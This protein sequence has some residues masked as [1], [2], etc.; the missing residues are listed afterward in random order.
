MNSIK[1][2][3]LTVLLLSIW[4]IPV[5]A[6]ECTFDIRLENPTEVKVIY[7]VKWWSHPFRT[8][9]PAVMAGGELGPNGS[10]TTKDRPCGTWSVEFEGTGID[11]THAFEQVDSKTRIFKVP[12]PGD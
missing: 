7:W 4:A 1:K 3:L 8:W 11:Y 2:L 9:R 12:F 10:F 5:F 6:E